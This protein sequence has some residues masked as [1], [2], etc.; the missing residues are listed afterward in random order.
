MLKGKKVLL[1]ITGAIAAY[2]MCEFIR[3]LQK[4]GA[5][6]K[7]VVTPNALKFVT[8][9]TLQTLSK[10]KIFTQMFEEE[11]N[12]SPEHISL[13]DDADIFIIAPASANT[14]SK[15][16][17]GICD[18][19]L[20]TVACAF[21]KPV[22]LA[23]SMNCN[24]WDN[25]IIQKNLSEL[26]KTGYYICPPDEGYLACGYEG[27]GRLCNPDKLLE[28]IIEILNAE[29]KFEG[30][31]IIITAGGTREKIDSVRFISNF[32]SGKMGFA[33][34]DRACEQGAD[35]TLITTRPVN[36]KYKVIDVESALEM[37]QAVEKEFKSADC[38][39]MTAAV[40]D[41]RAKKIEDKKIKKTS[42]EE[43]SLELIKNPDILKEIVLK[44]RKNQLIIGFCAESEN[45]LEFAKSKMKT[46]GCDFLIANDISRS[47]TGFSSDYNEV[48]IVDKNLKIEKINR[49]LKSQIAERIL[50]IISLKMK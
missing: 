2:K 33:L 24:M 9:L 34:A 42:K 29:K 16:A 38:L 44:R 8:G 10:N 5:E 13:A 7:V 4:K 46:K 6:V 22:M 25:K 28:K 36:K 31:K 20:T 17:M 15:L 32:S 3:T 27:T 49:A 47:D 45:V 14:I 12:Y 11:E 41:Y 30:K 50:D 39:I 43:I 37:K 18:N 40:A 1:G 26:E 21:K 23:P 19:L 35:V 48:Y